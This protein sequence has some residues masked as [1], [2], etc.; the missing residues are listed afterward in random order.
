MPYGIVILNSVLDTKKTIGCPEIIQRGRRRLQKLF[1]HVHMQNDYGELCYSI[2][3]H[4]RN[5]AR[6]YF[7]N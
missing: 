4:R 1:G 7:K 5:S 6:V 2:E 3:R